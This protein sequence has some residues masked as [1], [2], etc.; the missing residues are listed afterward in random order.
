MSCTASVPAQMGRAASLGAG[1][2]ALGRRIAAALA[3]R[4]E[5]R[6]LMALDE[7]ALKDMGFNKGQAQC[8]ASRTFW[9]V[10]VDRLRT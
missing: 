3:V 9:D 8:E 7:A 10:P 6:A 1:V 5:R 2:H 4:A